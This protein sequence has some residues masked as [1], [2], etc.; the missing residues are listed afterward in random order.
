[1]EKRTIQRLR[2]VT[3][4]VRDAVEAVA[5]EAQRA[6][7]AFARR[8]YAVLSRIDPINGPVRAIERVQFAITAIA[9]GAVR[10]VNGIAGDVVTKVIDGLEA[11]T[12]A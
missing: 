12:A 4:L 11:G 9:Y 1:M 3:A 6:H 5:T 7:E 2:G 8:P 10:S